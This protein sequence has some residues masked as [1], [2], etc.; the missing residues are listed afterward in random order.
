MS[1]FAYQSPSAALPGPGSGRSSSPRRFR[2]LAVQR[3]AFTLR[4]EQILRIRPVLFQYNELSRIEDQ[5][6][7]HIGVLAQ[8]ILPI[9]PYMVREEAIGKVVREIENGVDEILDPGDLVHV[10]DPPA[11]DYLLINA[12]QQQQKLIEELTARIEALEQ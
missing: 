7:R 10:F 3:G 11:F 12:F 4:L 1:R 2:S 6:T 9:A 8:E 5:E